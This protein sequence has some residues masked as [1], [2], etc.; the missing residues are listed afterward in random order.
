M[1]FKGTNS[2]TCYSL[3]DITMI[4]CF[5]MARVVVDPNPM[6]TTVGHNAHTHSHLCAV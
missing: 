3:F 1:N 5:T 4:H 2:G 6:D